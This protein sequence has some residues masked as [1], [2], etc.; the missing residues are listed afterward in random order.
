MEKLT[1]ILVVAENID[2]GT[3][4][5]EKTMVLARGFGARVDLLICDTRDMK[6]FAML[7]KERGYDEVVLCSV[8]R[9]GEPIIDLILRRVFETSPDLVVKAAAATPGAR[10][11]GRDDQHLAAACPAPLVFMR[12]QPWRSPV[13]IAAAVDVS[14]DN[15]ALARSIVHTSGF[16]NLGLEGELDVFYSEREQQDEVMRMAHAVKL[17]RLVREFHV[18]GER[19]RHLD[20]KPEETLPPIAASDD[21]DILVIG[22]LTQRQ[23]FSAMHAT[24]TRKLV[25]AC[26]GDVVLIKEEERAAP[27]AREMP[28]RLRATS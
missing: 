22:A 4:I 28:L 24:L 3:R 18:E 13:R 6:G 26:S 12:Y 23:G 17:A 21:Y 2:S 8:F 10:G 16:L 25:A 1:S 27:V 14:G 15:A 19:L 9:S 5:L 20:G 11:F 7:C